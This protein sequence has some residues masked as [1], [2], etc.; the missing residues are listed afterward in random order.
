MRADNRQT[1]A[2]TANNPTAPFILNIPR[3][4]DG[5]MAINSFIPDM[6]LFNKICK[7][8][9]DARHKDYRLVEHRTWKTC[10]NACVRCR[11]KHRPGSCQGVFCTEIITEEQE[12][13]WKVFKKYGD[14]TER[15]YELL[16]KCPHPR[17]FY[18][19]RRRGK[20]RMLEA[21]EGFDWNDFS[22]GINGDGGE[23]KKETKK[24]DG[25]LDYN[26]GEEREDGDDSGK[27]A[28]K[29]D[30][31]A[32]DD[33]GRAN[34]DAKS[35]VKG[36]SDEKK[37][38]VGDGSAKKKKKDPLTDFNL[39]VMLDEKTKRKRK[40]QFVKKDKSARSK[41]RQIDPGAAARARANDVCYR[42]WMEVGAFFPV[43]PNVINENC[44][45]Y[46]YRWDKNQPPVRS[47]D[48]KE[49]EECMD[50]YEIDIHFVDFLDNTLDKQLKSWVKE[51]NQ[52][53]SLQI[54]YTSQVCESAF[55]KSAAKSGSLAETHL[56]RGS[57]VRQNNLECG[58][59]AAGVTYTGYLP[60]MAG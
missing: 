13:D 1:Q 28:D 17:V 60:S 22:D 27:K 51:L 11:K 44:F 43:L 7:F 31:T 48:F 34:K 50:K 46:E 40:A 10:E 12:T 29:S 2:R 26:G 41:T 58:P 36:Q 19:E 4:R 24:T 49:F 39:R 5:D 37:D 38:T 55:I 47:G 3:V 6:S 18:E 9:G 15:G 56:R 25:G 54:K 16:Q 42:S 14:L 21:F 32:G 52:R 53:S 23:E 57:S 30:D 59:I 35:G 45:P 33:N 20:I 8:C